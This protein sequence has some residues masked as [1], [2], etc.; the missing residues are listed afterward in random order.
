MNA[1]EEYVGLYFQEL[2][3]L[4]R[5]NYEMNQFKNLILK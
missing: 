3:P 4:Q 2:S 1:R 5:I